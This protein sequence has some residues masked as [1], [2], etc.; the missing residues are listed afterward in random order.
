MHKIFQRFPAHF[1]VSSVPF[2]GFYG[3]LSAEIFHLNI[4]EIEFHIETCFRL[5]ESKILS[6]GREERSG[7]DIYRKNS[8]AHYIA[9]MN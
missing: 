7:R 1:T 8:T 5:V 3:I 4:S 6:F 2:R 9:I